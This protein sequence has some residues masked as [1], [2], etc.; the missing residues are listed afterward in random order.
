M[1]KRIDVRIGGQERIEQVEITET[2]T[3]GEV[4]QVVGCPANDYTLS[5]AVGMPPFG[6][7]EKIFDRVKEGGKVI[8]APKADAGNG[9]GLRE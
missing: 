4:L 3:A 6:G 9:V 5:P 2:S 8:A 1:Q 7:D